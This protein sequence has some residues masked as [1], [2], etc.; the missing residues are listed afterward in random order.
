[1]AVSIV[2]ANLSGT[3]VAGAEAL[4]CTGALLAA[5]LAA[6]VVAGLAGA[7]ALAGLAAVG[8]LAGAAAWPQADSA[9]AAVP[10]VNVERRNER[11]E[12]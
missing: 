4:P 8:L 3:F 7:L 5:G 2:Q 10:Q 11:R 1:L 12:S 6:V 9:R